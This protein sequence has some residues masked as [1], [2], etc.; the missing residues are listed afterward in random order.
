MKIGCFAKIFKTQVKASNKSGLATKIILKKI[1][2][3]SCFINVPANTAPKNVP[4]SPMKI[5]EGCQFQNKN[6]NKAPTISI[7]KDL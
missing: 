6:P 2:K 7:N 3:L 1:S 4:T 5:L